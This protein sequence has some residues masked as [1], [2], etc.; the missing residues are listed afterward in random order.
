MNRGFTLIELL[1]VIAILLILTVS[2]APFYSQFVTQND[3]FLTS[4][5]IANQIRKAQTYAVSGRRN[6]NWG[7]YYNNNTITLFSGNSYATRTSAL[8]ENW[9]FNPNFSIT[10]FTEIVFS[11]PIGVGSTNLTILVSYLGKQKTITVN[12]QGMV[13]QP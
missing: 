10:G 6:S 3:L 9:S 12:K 2:A 8:D 5:Q 11:G 4:D 7:V 13:E 1:L